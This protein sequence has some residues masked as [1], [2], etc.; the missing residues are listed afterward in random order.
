[1]TN[2]YLLALLSS[3]LIRSLNHQI[4]GVTSEDFCNFK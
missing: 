4:L 3:N 2:V 1:M